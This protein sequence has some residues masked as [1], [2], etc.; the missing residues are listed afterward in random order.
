MLSLKFNTT[1]DECLLDKKAY[2][3]T[4]KYVNVNGILYPI[5]H[6]FIVGEIDV[7]P[8][9]GCMLECFNILPPF[10]GTLEQSYNVTGTRSLTMKFAHIGLEGVEWFWDLFPGIV[11]PERRSSQDYWNIFFNVDYG[12]YERNEYRGIDISAR[13]T[14]NWNMDGFGQPNH[15]GNM[16]QF[17]G[18]NSPGIVNASRTV[19]TGGNIR[20]F[21]ESCW[22]GLCRP[23]G[24]GWTGG[25]WQRPRDFVFWIYKFRLEGEARGLRAYGSTWDL[26]NFIFDPDDPNYI[27]ENLPQ[28]DDSLF[29][30]G[31][32]WPDVWAGKDGVNCGTKVISGKFA[33][34]PWLR[35]PT[36]M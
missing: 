16:Q 7:N 11:A 5:T 15:I 22:N 34:A 10:L 30:V 23:S 24:N 31:T 2:P 19:T 35:Y 33:E 4:H 9:E 27:T 26:P 14:R 6:K 28:I 12:T 25:V 13:F 1:K 36:L 29:E 8:Y 18:R 20:F 17:V 32:Y 21:D 3:T